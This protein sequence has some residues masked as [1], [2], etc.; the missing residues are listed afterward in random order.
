MTCSYF[1][2]LNILAIL[3]NPLSVNWLSLMHIC[4]NGRLL[5]DFT[6][7]NIIS[8]LLSPNEHPFAS[9]LVSVFDF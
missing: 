9:S 2:F 4:F 5:F 3:T 6:A 1:N 8:A 7:S